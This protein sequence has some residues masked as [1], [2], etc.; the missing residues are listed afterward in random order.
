M[1]DLS[2]RQAVLAWLETGKTLTPM[3]ALYEFG[4]FRLGARV[5]ELRR[6]GWNVITDMVE[7]GNGK[8]VAQYRLAA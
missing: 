3:Q 2:Q 4:C 8:R 6:Q 7:V 5:E 1:A